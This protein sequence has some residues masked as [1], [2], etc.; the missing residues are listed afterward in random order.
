[1]RSELFIDGRW[2]DGGGAAFSVIDPALD[3]EA[4][5]GRAATPVD[6]TAA[7]AAARKAFSGWARTP[8]E[9]RIA[10]ARAFAKEVD[11]RK[12]DLAQ[13][14]SR[15]MGKALWDCRGEAAAVINKVELSIKAMTERAGVKDEA[16]AFGHTALNHRPHGV[17]AVLGPFNFPAHLP[18]GHIVPALLAGNT[19]V[20]KPSELAP[21]AGAILADCWDK[22]GLPAGVLNVVQ[23]GRETGAALLDGD[24]DGVLFTGSAQTGVFIHQKFAGRP[25]ITLAL[26]MGGNNPLIVWPP[27]DAEAAANLIVHSAFVTTGQR[28]SCARRLILPQGA[29]GDE[30]LDRLAA[31]AEAVR[32]GRPSDTPEPFIG[33]LVSVAAARRMEAVEKEFIAR[34]AR[35]VTKTRAQGA[36]VR[37]AILSLP[38]GVD[39]P[40]EELFAPFLLVYRT[41]TFEEALARANATRFGLAGGLISDDPA[42]WEETQLSLRAGVLNWNRPTT[43]ASSALPF[44][45]FGLSGNGRPSAYYAADYAAHPVAMQTAAKAVKIPAAGL[46]E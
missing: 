12:E 23:G 33:P 1:M 43:G 36:F 18:N 25:Q 5:R 28:C 9:T 35:W 42:L 14:I 10:I 16:A 21:G 7:I 30:V 37:P 41:A 20:F 29:Y 31:L 22:A 26:E 6:V 4:W 3:V 15:E 44:G 32:V 2:R 38:A 45:G 11:A 40:D 17:M 46:P 39:A 19:V 34:G 13:L 24:I 8:V 27:A